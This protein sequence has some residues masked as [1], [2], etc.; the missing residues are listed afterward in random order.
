[1]IYFI[2]FVVSAYGDWGGPCRA[3][4]AG[5]TRPSPCGSRATP[6]EDE[7]LAIAG[8]H[9]RAVYRLRE[10]RIVELD[11]EVIPAFLAALLPRGAE[12]DTTEVHRSVP[13]PK[14]A[15]AKSTAIPSRRSRG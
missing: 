11:R 8:L 6:H 9:Q 4:P 14:P 13:H 7:T 15:A 2:L 12:L 3:A 10:R 5:L 1:M